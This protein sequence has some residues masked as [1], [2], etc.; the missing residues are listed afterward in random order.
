MADEKMVSVLLPASLIDRVEAEWDEMHRDP[1]VAALRPRRTATAGCTM[2][3]EPTMI[4]F[5]S[6]ITGR[7]LARSSVM[8]PSVASDWSG[9]AIAVLSRKGTG[10]M[11]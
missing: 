6:E 3:C 5:P 2:R 9:S 10:S 7:P 8:L 1:T 4:T 11:K